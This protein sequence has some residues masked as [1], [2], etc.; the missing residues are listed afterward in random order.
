MLKCVWDNNFIGDRH[1]V[2]PH[3]V[4]ETES[5]LQMWYKPKDL[6][7]GKNNEI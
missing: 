1:V 4:I 7:Q 2:I 6:N 3:V 5:S